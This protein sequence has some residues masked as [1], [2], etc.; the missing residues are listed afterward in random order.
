MTQSISG[1]ISFPSLGSGTDFA[2]MIEKLKKIE[3]IPK[4]RMEL[5]K[6][7]WELRI[8]AFDEIQSQLRTSKTVF[9][10]YSK[11][12]SMLLRAVE[13][14][15]SAVA[16]AKASGNVPEGNYGIEVKQLA[17][18]A[19]WSNKKVYNKDTI[20][21]ATESPQE[22][23][24]AYKGVSRSITVPK[25]MTIEQLV[26]RINSDTQ[27][28]G[29]KAALIKN[30]PGYVFQLQGKDTGL[31]AAL[32]VS[33]N[34][35]GFG[36][37][38]NLSGKDMVLNNTSSNQS[39]TYMYKGV[40][41]T[42]SIP[43]GA[44]A[45]EFLK[46]LNEDPNNPG[47]LF[48]FKADG[49]D[50]RLHTQD[51]ETKKD[52]ILPGSGTIP[53]L[54]MLSTFTAR[55]AIINDTGAVQPYTWSL[56]GTN[57][58]FDVPAGTTLEQFVD[59][60]NKSKGN[61]GV[62]ASLVDDGTGVFSLK[63]QEIDTTINNSGAAANISYYHNG[64]TVNLAVPDGTS[65][66]EFVDL[67]NDDPN[68]AGLTARMEGGPSGYTVNF[69]DTEKNKLVNPPMDT[70]IAALRKPFRV[71]DP[72]TSLN[73]TT[74]NKKFTYVQGDKEITVDLKPGMNINQLASAINSGN[75]TVEASVVGNATDGFTLELKDKGTGDPIPLLFNSNST[76]VDSKGVTPLTDFSDTGEVNPDVSTKLTALGGMPSWS[77][78]KLVANTTGGNLPFTYTY[79]GSTVTLDVPA[80]TTM[81]EFVKLFNDDPANAGVVA[82]LRATGAGYV[83]SMN[84]KTTGNIVNLENITT[85]MELLK[86]APDNWYIR[87]AQDARFNLNGWPQEFTSATNTLN[88]EY[89]DGLTITMKSVGKTEFTV[90][91]DTDGMKENIK[92]FVTSINE[93]RGKIN[94]LTKVDKDKEI[95]EYD[96]KKLSSQMTWQMGS[97]LTGN[98]GVQLL[99]TRLNNILATPL[100]GYQ[101]PKDKDDHVYNTFSSAGIST[102]T[103]ESDP[104]FGLLRIDEKKLDEALSKNPQSVAEL[105]SA[106]KVASTDSLDFSIANTTSSTKAGTYK[107]AYSVDASGNPYDVYINGA[108]ATSDSEFPGRFT[109][110]D[111][112]NPAAGMAI[113]FSIGAL[114]E[115]AYTSSIHVKQGKG[116][117]LAD[118]CYKEVQNDKENNERGSIPILIDNYRDIVKNIEKKITRETERI[119]QWETRMKLKFARLDTLLGQ[120]DKQMEKNASALAQAKANSGSSS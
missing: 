116:G 84:D 15:D 46:A 38:K 47:V 11:L 96:P 13:S 119:S 27:N 14:S 107:V 87:E 93:L 109:V 113:Q 1:G 2:A 35:E 110:A 61:P 43:P 62:R 29:V 88:E 111:M 49:S 79:K 32:T 18:S 73:T 36:G 117:E 50:I 118:F 115:G 101:M 99:T 33:S 3:E 106:D 114:S 108:L 31:E 22:F 51:A 48:S 63:F 42:V 54:G 66:R 52:I 34:V 4:T 70:D 103:D 69:Y 28:P 74:A 59:L 68:N 60:F 5:W 77:G 71:S 58:S 56:N 6:A 17:T 120:Y 19:I 95:K 104:E 55:D 41:S 37:P 97:A 10:S 7:E 8:A 9:D 86:A 21:N 57:H 30:G 75:P 78:K 90:S 16:T 89:M 25:G 102:V 94:E 40:E 81:E 65:M 20:I 80:G 53:E 91:T 112:N 82:S 45:D 26:S 24:Y 12:G 98:Y 83:L 100:I 64:K 67:F 85:D 44:T 72:A 76:T 92:A 23:S 39:Y 105:F